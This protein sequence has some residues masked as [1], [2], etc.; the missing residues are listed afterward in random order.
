ME[1]SELVVLQTHDWRIPIRV[2]Q[3][4]PDNLKPEPYD[5]L[6][7]LL[8]DKGYSCIGHNGI[9]RVCVSN[10]TRD[11]LLA[12]RGANSRTA[13]EEQLFEDTVRAM[14]AR[15]PDYACPKNSMVNAPNPGYW[16]AQANGVRRFV[17]HHTSRATR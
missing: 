15:D 2:L 5:Q 8:H 12:S 6:M 7:G 4:E 10:S 13:N 11:L 16:A 3:F 17:R 1:G 9:D 14:Q